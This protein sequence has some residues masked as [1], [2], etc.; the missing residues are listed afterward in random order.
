MI[1]YHHFLPKETEM[2]MA[3]LMRENLTIDHLTI[4][5]FHFSISVWPGTMASREWWERR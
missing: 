5:I 4:Q 2:F 1:P 3:H